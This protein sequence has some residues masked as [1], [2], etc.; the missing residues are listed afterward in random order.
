MVAYTVPQQRKKEESERLR[1]ERDEIKFVGLGFQ[2]WQVKSW[3]P[4]NSP[5]TYLGNK[6]RHNSGCWQ[7]LEK[8]YIVLDVTGSIPPLYH[9][10]AP[11]I[12]SSSSEW[13]HWVKCCK[14]SIW[15]PYNSIALDGITLP[16]AR[17][18]HGT[19]L[20][21]VNKYQESTLCLTK[22]QAVTHGRNH[23]L[24]AT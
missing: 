19:E 8:M 18:E 1:G 20:I 3:M 21:Q 22:F 5:S 7:L 11:A 23:E 9:F 6:F 16:G 10:L 12:R 15:P 2:R 14:E 4:H 17:T 24:T 13:V